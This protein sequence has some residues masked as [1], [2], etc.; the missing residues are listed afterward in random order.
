MTGIVEYQ[1]SNMKESE[2]EEEEV[3][4]HVEFD[5]EVDSGMFNADLPFKIIGIDSQKPLMQVGNKVR[6]C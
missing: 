3:L 6:K 1:D 2:Y 4:V 5:C